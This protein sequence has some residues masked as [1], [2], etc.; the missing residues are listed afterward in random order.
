M[1]IKS[2]HKLDQVEFKFI[3]V[4]DQLINQYPFKWSNFMDIIFKSNTVYIKDST[5]IIELI[6]LKEEE[7]IR[8]FQI[9]KIMFN[10]R[11]IAKIIYKHEF[12]VISFYSLFITSFFKEQ[13][14]WLTIPLYVD[15]Y[16]SKIKIY[17]DIIFNNQKYYLG[18]MF[19]HKIITIDSKNCKKIK[20]NQLPL[21]I[22]SNNNYE[23]NLLFSFNKDQYI[24]NL[25]DKLSQV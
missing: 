22:S 25:F 16:K 15:L 14:K 20:L 1:E 18:I 13:N 4:V 5:M 10:Q 8:I 7:I 12:I 2:Y 6:H 17:Y 3:K 21:I 9:L 23:N 11:I 19:K 24:N